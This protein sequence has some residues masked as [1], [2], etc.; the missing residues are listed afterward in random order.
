[1]PTGKVRFFDTEKGFGFIESDEGESVFLHTSAL[2]DGVTT[3]SKG[4]RVEFSMVDG[5]KGPQALYVTIVPESPSLRQLRRRSPQTMVT[6][7]ED[8]IKL[9]DASSDSLRRGKYPENGDKIAQLLRA[10]ADDF[11]A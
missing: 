11:D 4:A 3:V 9:L 2:P 1:M 7:V 8:L 5:R 10:V 6:L